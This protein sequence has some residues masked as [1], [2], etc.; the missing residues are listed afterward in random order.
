ME[1]EQVAGSV[2]RPSRGMHERSVQLAVKGGYIDLG[3]C[4]ARVGVIGGE[5]QEMLAIG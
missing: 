3:A 2:L 4:T 1:I 5:V